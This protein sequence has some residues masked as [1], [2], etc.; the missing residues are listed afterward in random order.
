MSLNW[1]RNLILCLFLGIGLSCGGEIKKEATEQPE[2]FLLKEVSCENKAFRPSKT[3]TEVNSL[4]DNIA[5]YSSYFTAYNGWNRIQFEEGSNSLNPLILSEELINKEFNL[6]FQKLKS[7]LSKAQY[8]ALLSRDEGAFD[9]VENYSDVKELFK[10]VSVLQVKATRWNA[11]Q[12]QL[13]ALAGKR[14]LDVR[15]YVLLKS[16]ECHSDHKSKECLQQKMK[17]ESFDL[18]KE[19]LKLCEMSRSKTYCASEYLISRRQRNHWNF[20]KT[21]RDKAL[22][23]RWAP[24]FTLRYKRSFQCKKN[25]ENIEIELPIYFGDNS[26]RFSGGKEALMAFVE[27]KWSSENIQVKFKEVLEKAPGVVTFEFAKV[28]VSYVRQDK[29]THIV[30]DDALSGFLLNLTFAHELGHVLGF[31][32]C[33]IEFYEPRKKELVYYSLN[34]GRKNLMCSLDPEY[35]AP[36]KYLEE[37]SKSSCQY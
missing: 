37:L 1:K 33:Y 17:S 35:K 21:Y 22:K 18:D 25:E 23:K 27:E 5:L 3:A 31:P 10:E 9:F 19:I 16:K 28:G 24:Q 4:Y 2:V 30:L 8:D 29:P 7:T 32:D 36:A 11:K 6:V 26:Y 12:C 15:S 34:D 13:T 20:Y 14:N